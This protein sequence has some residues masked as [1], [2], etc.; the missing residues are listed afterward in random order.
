MHV[1]LTN[2][3]HEKVFVRR[4]AELIDDHG[5]A[6]D[7]SLSFLQTWMTITNAWYIRTAYPTEE[8]HSCGCTLTD[9]AGMYVLSKCAG[10]RYTILSFEAAYKDSSAKPRVR[11]TR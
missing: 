5:L 1:L 9:T 6:S 3:I 7:V 2:N 10:L 11:R 4:S 8:K